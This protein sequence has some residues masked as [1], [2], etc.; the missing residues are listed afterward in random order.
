[1]RTT[2]SVASYVCCFRQTDAV[3]ALHRYVTYVT[4]LSCL[5]LSDLLSCARVLQMLRRI[6]V[7]LLDGGPVAS[8]R[9]AAC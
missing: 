5:C 6:K 7:R 4:K 9:I 3:L 2:V 1:M 8:A